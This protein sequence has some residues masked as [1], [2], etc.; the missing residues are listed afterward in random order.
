MKTYQIVR[1]LEEVG[2]VKANSEDEAYDIADAQA[3][4]DIKF[5]AQPF[6]YEVN[7]ISYD[8]SESDKVL[9]HKKYRENVPYRYDK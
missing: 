5:I 3:I 2:Y 7:S 4:E 9:T 6:G 8:I 1:T